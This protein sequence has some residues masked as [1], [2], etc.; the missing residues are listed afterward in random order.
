MNIREQEFFTWTLLNAVTR[1]YSSEQ[2]TCYLSLISLYMALFVMVWTLIKCPQHSHLL[3]YVFQNDSN[4][5][6]KLTN[7]DTFYVITEQR[8]LDMTCLSHNST[9]PPPNQLI[10]N[11]L[12]KNSPF[13]ILE[14]F[15][16]CNCPSRLW[17]CRNRRLTVPE[18]PWMARLG[19]KQP[20]WTSETPNMQPVTQ[21]T[22]YM[23]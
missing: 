16:S 23:P 21:V 18:G 3:D 9:H 19:H 2:I 7:S 4:D 8:T 22:S 1:R 14:T 17:F 11:N 10:P 20:S 5:E 6:I 13:I 12:F 15:R